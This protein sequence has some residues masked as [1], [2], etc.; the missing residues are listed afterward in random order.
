MK[1]TFLGATGTVTGSKY[2]VE[3]AGRRV[4]VDCG[5]F[6]GLKTLRLRNWAPLPVDPASVDAV[7]LTHAH[8]DHSGYIPRLVEQGFRGRVHATPATIALCNLLLPDS[9]H[10]Q[11]DEAKFA[12]RH[13]FSKH[14]PALPLY[15]EADARRALERF[16]AHDF[17]TDFEPVPGL[18]AHFNPAGHILGAASARLST[19]DG[20]IL[21]SGDLGRSDDL[22]MRP[23]APPDA[24]DV[25]LV[26]STYGNR[27]HAGADLL[28][29]LADVVSR[30]A[31]RGGIVVVPA[32]A[33]GRA[34]ALLHALRL[35]KDAGRIP[36]LPVFL[37]SPMAADVTS[38]FL[39]H[40]ELHRLG[41]AQCAEMCRGVRFVTSEEESRALN[42]LRY[43]A[44]ILS[45]SGMATGGRVVHH[46][47]AFAPDPRNAIVFAG[48][49][50]MGTRGAALVGGAKQIRIH[51]E[52]VPVRAEVTSIEG[53]S[54]HADRDELLAWIGAL[55]AAP[56]RVYVTH[57]EPEA[58]DA[59]RQAI[60]ERHGWHC[61]VPEYRES[62]DLAAGVWPSA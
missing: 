35:L 25:V 60:A 51:G 40:P 44:V 42:D 8:I 1:L 11:E 27:L 61:T 20:A 13:G 55:P 7:V 62:I 23:P 29:A 57:G 5:L 50:A 53:F 12:N 16:D 37:N 18:K 56:R 54:A 47:K 2:L 26:E 30:T 21:F 22:L 33:V 14:A 9:G 17:G 43:P 52:W 15:T 28:G 6:Q 3:H 38:L 34:Q 32:F 48:Y 41:A 59:L 36:D 39:K 58:A 49:Q 24:A 45:A 10:L 31:A 46:L 19:G 4:L